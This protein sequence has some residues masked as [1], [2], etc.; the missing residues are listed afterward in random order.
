MIPLKTYCDLFSGYTFRSPLNEVFQSSVGVIQLKDVDTR[1][2]EIIYSRWANSPDFSGSG[3][4]YLH[5]QDILLIAKGVNNMAFIYERSRHNYPLV[6][7]AGA[8]II[9]RP[10]PEYLYSPFVLWYLN[11][12]E[13]QATFKR[14]QAGTTVPNLSIDTL[15]GFTLKVPSLQKQR[16]IGDTYIL[17]REHQ[18]LSRERDEKWLQL[19]NYQIKNLI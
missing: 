18:R 13:T 16:S 3:R 17:N 1:N 15:Y 2:G 6:V 12:P 10:M 19:F 4:Y 14:L 8:F 11:L 9:I 7:A 5:D